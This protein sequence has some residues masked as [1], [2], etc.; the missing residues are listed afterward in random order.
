[1]TRKKTLKVSRDGESMRK[2]H[3]SEQDCRKE[4]EGGGGE[5]RSGVV[6]GSLKMD[7]MG[8]GKEGPQEWHRKD[9]VHCSETI[10]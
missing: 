7:E 2:G 10:F 1:M 4:K 3:K 9:S 6:S 5:N 8:S